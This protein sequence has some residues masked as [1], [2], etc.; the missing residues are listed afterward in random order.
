M[1]RAAWGHTHRQ[2]LLVSM[3]TADQQSLAPPLD[4]LSLRPVP[5]SPLR[6]KGRRYRRP[7]GHHEAALK[8]LIEKMNGDEEDFPQHT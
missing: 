4:G 8:Q 1:F 3:D 6:V 2:L 5:A 7:K